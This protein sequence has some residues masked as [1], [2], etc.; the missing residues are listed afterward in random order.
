MEPSI[1]QAAVAQRTADQPAVMPLRRP[2]G[3]RHQQGTGLAW[4]VQ[5]QLERSCDLV[6]PLHSPLPPGSDQADADAGIGTVPAEVRS[7]LAVLCLAT[8]ARRDARGRRVVGLSIPEFVHSAMEWFARRPDW[9]QASD[10]LQLQAIWEAIEALVDEDALAAFH[11]AAPD[12]VASAERRLWRASKTEKVDSPT[13]DADARAKAMKA[14]P[15]R[16]MN[17]MAAGLFGA[18][19][20]AALCPA[21][22]RVVPMFAATAGQAARDRL[23]RPAS[24]RA[25]MSRLFIKLLRA[26]LGLPAPLP[27]NTHPLEAAAVGLLPVVMAVGAEHLQPVAAM[28]ALGLAPGAPAL[29]DAGLPLCF[30]RETL[31][32]PA[33]LQAQA[34]AALL[35]IEQP[36]ADT[37]LAA[38]LDAVQTL[39]RDLARTVTDPM[40]AHALGFE[41]VHFQAWAT[42]L[43][44]AAKTNRLPARLLRAC[45]DDTTAH[46]LA[47]DF[48][49]RMKR[50]KDQHS[51][52]GGQPANTDLD[53]GGMGMA[54]A[55]RTVLWDGTEAVR[56]AVALPLLK[57]RPGR[58][59]MA[60]AAR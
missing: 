47:E 10:P 40:R 20:L 29:D 12:F 13:A 39:A 25:L 31:Q 3:V 14:W 46:Y 11:A 28:L 9:P 43:E 58:L 8:V 4:R 37:A 42:Q 53:D 5:M 23:Q 55:L 22:D 30:G 16:L 48:L 1:E 34:R 27:G 6:F 45:G 49:P 60:P 36:P 41:G 2:A 19:E 33:N 7:R 21:E 50:W 26:H 57:A 51:A 56:A 54:E 44:H 24:R 59:R 35:G 32:S 38:L 18:P 17:T 52:M 15:K